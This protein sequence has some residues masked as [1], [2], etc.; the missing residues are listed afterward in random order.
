MVRMMVNGMMVKAM[1]EDNLQGIVA[2]INADGIRTTW[3]SQI[4]V[5]SP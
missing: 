3:H 4:P 1:V 5:P 2:A